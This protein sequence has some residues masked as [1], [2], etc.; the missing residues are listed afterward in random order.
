MVH[1]LTIIYI[2]IYIDRVSPNGGGDVGGPPL[3]LFHDF[4]EIPNIKTNA[5]HGVTP[6]LKM[7]PPTKKYPPPLP[8]LLKNEAPFKKMS[9]RKSNQKIGN[10]HLAKIPQKHNFLSWSIQNFTKK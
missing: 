1:Y 2:F 3:P 6:H 4:F 9:P 7:K 8:L 10:C 5:T